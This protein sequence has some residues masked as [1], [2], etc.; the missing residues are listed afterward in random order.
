[1]TSQ[2][3][4]VLPNF[5]R[6]CRFHLAKT[7]LEIVKHS[8]YA[9]GIKQRFILMRVTLEFTGDFLDEV[10]DADEIG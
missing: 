2:K 1:L 5:A 10:L 4:T 8:F 3:L 9:I 7:L 6:N